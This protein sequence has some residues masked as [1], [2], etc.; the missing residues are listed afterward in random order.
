MRNEIFAPGRVWAGET[1][2]IVAGGPSLSLK[3]VREIGVARAHDRCRVIA[4]S[5]AVYPCW[6]ADI[7]FSS[8]AKWWDHHLGVPSFKGQKVSRNCLGRYDVYYLRETGDTGFDPTPGTV[9][10]GSNSGHQA[11]H[12]AAQLGAGRIVLVAMDFSDGGARD[13]WFGLHRG[14]M[15]MY[16]ETE[17]WR[18]ALRVL[19]AELANREIE[20]VNASLASTI[21]WLPMTTLE[22]AL[23]A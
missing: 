16:S 15:D 22:S 13:H 9:R 3:Q 14:S 17:K 19:T 18:S 2:V 21:T 11:V 6:F 1:A 10:H 8:D 20:V 12:L 7:C 5:D 23:A 4:V